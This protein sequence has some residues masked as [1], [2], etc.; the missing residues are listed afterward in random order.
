MGDFHTYVSHNPQ[1]IA[2]L[3]WKKQQYRWPKKESSQD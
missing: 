3:S 2:S 1:M